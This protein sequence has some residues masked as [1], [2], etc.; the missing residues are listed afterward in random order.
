MK[1]VVILTRAG[2]SA[3]C[4]AVE[5]YMHRWIAAGHRVLV[6][7]GTAEPPAGDIALMHVDL[8]V[9]PSEYAALAS[10]YP[11]TLNGAALDIRRRRFSELQLRPGDPYHGPVIV[12]TDANFG[13][14]PEHGTDSRGRTPVDWGSARTLDPLRYPV[15][16][17]LARVPPEVFENEALIVERFLDTRHG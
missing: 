9:V 15:F 17:S 2:E 8:S 16:P 4:Y 12:K 13:G 14:V 6:H 1:T 3:R 10:A 5:Q 7:A 11:K